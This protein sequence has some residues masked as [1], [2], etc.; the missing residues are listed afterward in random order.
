MGN[1][2]LYTSWQAKSASSGVCPKIVLDHMHVYLFIIINV[3][4]CALQCLSTHIEL[5]TAL[6]TRIQVP[7]T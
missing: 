5:E 1:L 4:L 3:C 6:A 7:G 2:F